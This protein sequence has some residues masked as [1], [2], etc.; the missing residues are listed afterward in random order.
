MKYTFTTLI[1]SITKWYYLMNEQQTILVVDDELINIALLEGLLRDN[2]DVLS[3]YNG[4]DALKIV[5]N[6]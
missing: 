2:Y 3:A 4:A 5:S 1:F 6:I